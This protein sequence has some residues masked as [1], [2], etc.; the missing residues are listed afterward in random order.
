MREE[1]WKEVCFLRFAEPWVGRL[2][3]LQ[4]CAGLLWRWDFCTVFPDLLEAFWCIS[5]I[6]L[7]MVVI[8]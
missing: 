1:M 2:A 7:G 4:L 8:Y 5:L 6:D 3:K